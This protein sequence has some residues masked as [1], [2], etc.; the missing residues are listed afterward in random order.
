MYYISIRVGSGGWLGSPLL[1]LFFLL[2]LSTLF[3]QS[4]RTNDGS[5]LLTRVQTNSCGEGVEM[6]HVLG[7]NKMVVFCIMCRREDGGFICRMCMSFFSSWSHLSKLKIHFRAKPFP[8]VYNVPRVEKMKKM[9]TLIF[10]RVLV[11]YTSI[12]LPHLSASKTSMFRPSH[13]SSSFDVLA[14]LFIFRSKF[15]SIV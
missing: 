9:C 1:L 6:E 4:R 13:P 8:H 5:Y 3:S 12:R 11:V 14:T 2:Y 15:S 7:G 10:I